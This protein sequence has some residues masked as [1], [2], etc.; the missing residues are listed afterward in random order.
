MPD[1]YLR[2]S[3]FNGKLG[4][5]N[6]PEWKTVA[7]DTDGKAVA[8]SSIGQT[9][10]APPSATLIGSRDTW[11]SPV[12]VPIHNSGGQLEQ[13]SPAMSSSGLCRTKPDATDPSARE[14]VTRGCASASEP[15]SC[16][17]RA[18]SGCAAT[19]WRDLVASFSTPSDHE[20]HEGPTK[21]TMDCGWLNSGRHHSF[22]PFV[23]PSCPS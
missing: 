14:S 16:A 20:G 9:R 1:R 23:G 6:N 18:G 21:G 15:S 11:L 17:C 4:Q 10:L 8:T 5:G 3:D 19:G 7:F 2:A 13:L 22:V 12:V